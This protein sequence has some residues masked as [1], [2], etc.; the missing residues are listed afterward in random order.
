MSTLP[1]LLC[2]SF[3]KRSSSTTIQPSESRSP[4]LACSVPR[5][6]PARP[7]VAAGPGADH[8]AA[9]YGGGPSGGRRPWLRSCGGAHSGG[10]R[11]R[12]LPLRHRLREHRS[13]LAPEERMEIHTA[14]APSGASGFRGFWQAPAFFVA[15]FASGRRKPKSLDHCSFVC[16]LV[17][18]T[19]GWTSPLHLQCFACTGVVRCR[20]FLLSASWEQHLICRLN[21]CSLAAPS[22]C[23][24][25]FFESAHL[26]PC[27]IQMRLNEA[28]TDEAGIT[29]QR[30]DTYDP[31]PDD[32][33]LMQVR[34]RPRPPCKTALLA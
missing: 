10:S 30:P 19:P 13:K 20:A 23:V 14:S 16:S 34:Q 24:H 22:L 26:V 8:G 5:P 7:L 33:S 21:R 3:P 32:V 18:A 9:V 11:P 4:A 29:L 25:G 31:S 2:P 28:G 1:S 17:R 6:L 12:P 27:L 15:V